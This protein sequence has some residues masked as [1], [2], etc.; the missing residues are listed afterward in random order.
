MQTPWITPTITGY[1]PVTTFWTEF[2]QIEDTGF[3]NLKEYFQK[4]F[5]DNKPLNLYPQMTELI[6]VLNHK[7]WEHYEHGRYELSRIYQAL[8]EKAYDWALNHYPSGSTAL[9]YLLNTLD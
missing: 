4:V 3:V 9:S 6:M 8:Y 5:E 2:C 1:K 7:C